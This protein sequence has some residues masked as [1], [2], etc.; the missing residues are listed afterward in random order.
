M[1]SRKPTVAAVERV[2]SDYH[3]SK[4]SLMGIG[5]ERDYFIENLATLLASGMDVSVAI[6]A[7]KGGIRSKTMKEII[8]QVKDA[9]DS[10]STLWR[11]LEATQLLSGPVISL[12]RLGEESG[13]LSANLT[14]I[15]NQQRKDRLFRSKVRSAMLYPALVIIIG[16]VVSLGIS[17][18]ILPRLSTVFSSL[19]VTLPLITRVMIAVGAWVG[20]YGSLVIP[21]LLLVLIVVWYI[22]FVFHPT[23]HV[24]QRLLFALP[25]VGRL[26]QEVELAR[27]GYVL[28]TL[29]D[30]G[31][32]VPKSMRSLRDTTELKFYQSFYE[33][34][35][36]GVEE[37]NS[38]QKCFVAFGSTDQLIPPPIQQ[39][40]MA[41][42]RS[43]ILASTLLKI[44]ET[45]EDRAET[46]TKN[47][48]VLIEP[49]LL[50][51]IWV[52]VVAVAMA[53]ILPVYSILGGLN[54]M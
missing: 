12:V 33:N 14:V 52:G 16:I 19:H 2:S 43:G 31:L 38:F 40:M 29:L 13:Q 42:E 21:L 53:V 18:F 41:A 37:G 20:Q 1:P 7:I 46:T 5:K 26:I 22:L 50:A 17:W 27:F 25:G 6:E 8:G 54:R 51:L 15:V 30:A 4:I 35:R 45:F 23:K 49:V 34:L 10:G 11:A 32:T 9:V 28:G 36:Q 47:L 44:G 3:Y 48:S 24:G 39:M